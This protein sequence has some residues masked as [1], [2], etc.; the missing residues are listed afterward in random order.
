MSSNKRILTLR[1]TDIST[2]NA[3]ADYYNV[4][5]STAT[6]TVTN[7]RCNITFRNVS[8][9]DLMGHE[10]YEKFDKFRI[11]LAQ[12]YIGQSTTAI[13]ATVTPA[14]AQAQ[15]LGIWLSGV[16]FDSPV[17]IAGVGQ[18]QM[19]LMGTAQ[20]SILPLVAGAASGDLTNYPNNNFSYTFSKTA[21]NTD[22]NI[23]LLCNDTADFPAFTAATQ[24]RGQMVFTFV[25]EGIPKEET[26]QQPAPATRM[27]R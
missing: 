4:T 5:V 6:G 26:T 9:R 17:Y 7:N 2:L 8:F 14:L 13:A 18:Q 3:G 27:I 11:S 21:T 20:L 16:P 23:R 10:Y 15:N 1:T 24:L 19:A 25:V 22:L 12:S